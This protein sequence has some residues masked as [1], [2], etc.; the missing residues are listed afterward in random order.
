[1]L[2]WYPIPTKGSSMAPMTVKERTQ[3]A[4]A[5]R[6]ASAA[7]TLVSRRYFDGTQPPEAQEHLD[8]AGREITAALAIIR[9]ARN[10]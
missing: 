10:A 5:L 1:M 2:Y 3:P 6:D 7:R 8:R 9:E 4:L